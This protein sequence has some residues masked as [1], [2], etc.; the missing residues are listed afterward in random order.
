MEGIKNFLMK[1]RGAII[2]GIIAIIALLLNLHK[3]LI[4]ILII[5]AGIVIGNYVQHNKEIVKEKLKYYIDK[6]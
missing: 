3:I 5:V 6:L 2:G 1:Y 4:W